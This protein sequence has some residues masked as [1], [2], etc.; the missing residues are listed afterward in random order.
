MCF[1]VQRLSCLMEFL[2]LFKF[3]DY[4][5]TYLTNANKNRMHDMALSNLKQQQQKFIVFPAPK[6]S[7]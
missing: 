2:N 6:S 5:H 4:T 7:K 3:V 1:N